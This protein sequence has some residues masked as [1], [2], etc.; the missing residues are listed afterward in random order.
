MGG[1]AQHG[2]RLDAPWVTPCGDSSFIDLETF[3]VWF[4]GVK[5]GQFAGKRRTRSGKSSIYLLYWDFETLGPCNLM[6]DAPPPRRAS[7]LA[8]VR[9]W[10]EE[11]YQVVF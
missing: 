9:G 5:N 6:P 10:C 11:V 7:R 8:T 4:G 3:E 2:A 1:A